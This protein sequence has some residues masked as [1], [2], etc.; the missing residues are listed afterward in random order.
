MAQKNRAKAS[1]LLMVAIVAILLVVAGV[2]TVYM[3]RR[4]AATTP[5]D[6]MPGMTLEQLSVYNGQNG[7]PSY[8]AYEGKIYD[9]SGSPMF[10][11]GKHYSHYAGTDLS[12]RLEGA[13]HGVEV[14]VPFKI[15][16]RLTP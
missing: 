9:V 2:G 3:I 1:P 14:F 5:V 6:N 16:G 13:P 8:F 4:T 12:G 11:N 7:Q 15:V 10:K